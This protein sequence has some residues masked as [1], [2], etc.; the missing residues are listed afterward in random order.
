M[1]L[2]LELVLAPSAPG[3]CRPLEKIYINN[4]N[5]SGPFNKINKIDFSECDDYETTVLEYMRTAMG[6]NLSSLPVPT[7]NGTAHSVVS[8]GTGTGTGND[9]LNQIYICE[10]NIINI[11]HH[12][13]E[14]FENNIGFIKIINPIFV[15]DK[16]CK[17]SDNDEIFKN[18]Y[19]KYYNDIDGYYLIRKE[20]LIVA[21]TSIFN[22]SHDY[23]TKCE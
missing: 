7:T 21:S 16:T 9:N 23:P 20:D 12:N 17:I 2:V 18:K 6:C 10:N 3:P 5:T 13:A 14:K 19:V 22:S 1:E 11:E 4:N 15:S 8:Y